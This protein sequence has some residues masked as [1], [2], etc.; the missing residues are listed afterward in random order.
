VQTINKEGV[1]VRIKCC[2]GTSSDKRCCI[3]EIKVDVEEK[4]IWIYMS[5]DATK[6][7]SR[8]SQPDYLFLLTPETIEALKGELN[9]EG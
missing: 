3:D 8:P 6:H 9:K 2:N 5:E 1:V 7:P 4:E